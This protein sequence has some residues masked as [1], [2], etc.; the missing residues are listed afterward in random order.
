MA[1][2][3]A[4]GKTP[5]ASKPKEK[6]TAERLDY[7]EGQFLHYADRLEDI[8]IDGVPQ[9]PE[10]REEWLTKEFAKL[11][12][13]FVREN[14]RTGADVGRWVAEAVRAFERQIDT[15]YTPDPIATPTP[16]ADPE[17]ALDTP[18]SPA[19]M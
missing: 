8:E 16:P 1:P 19:D 10:Y 12:P 4:G 7:L 6:T 5:A 18:E 9:S 11:V 17:P 13:P 15:P 2:K 14:D 3:K